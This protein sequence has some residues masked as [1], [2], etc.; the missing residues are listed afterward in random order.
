M[1]SRFGQRKR[2]P[3][4]LAHPRFRAAF[5]FLVLRQ[6]ASAEHAEEITFWREAQAQ[7]GEELPSQFESANDLGEEEG[8]PRKRRRRRRSGSGTVATE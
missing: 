1:D 7:S 6:F 2:V 4:M 3:R 5:D 8:T